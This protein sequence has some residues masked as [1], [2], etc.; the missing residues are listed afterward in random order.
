MRGFLRRLLPADSAATNAR[1]LGTLT[2]TL[3]LGREGE[4]TTHRHDLRLRPRP[5]SAM[6]EAVLAAMTVST[7][8]PT[9]TP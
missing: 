4:E 5:I 9:R 6:L 2:L 3:S 7:H 8:Q 1:S